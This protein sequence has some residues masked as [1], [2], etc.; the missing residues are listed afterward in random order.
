[1][2]GLQADSDTVLMNCYAP[3]LVNVNKGAWQWG[4]NL[5]GYDA[6]SSFGS[7]SYYAQSMFAGNL[8][9]VNLATDVIPQMLPLPPVETPHG[10]IGVGTTRSNAEFKDIKVISGDQTLNQPDLAKK[11]DDWTP[12]TG[13]WAVGDGVLSQANATARDARDIAGDIG[14]RDY[15]LSLKARSLGDGGFAVLFHVHDADNMISLNVGGGDKADL[16]RI[17]GRDRDA[18]GESVAFTADTGKWYDVRI[19]LAGTDIKC[20]LDDKLLVQATD[21][22]PAPATPVFAAASRANDSGEVILKVVNVGG[23]SQQIEINLT[24]VSQVAKEADVETLTGQPEDANTV[25][26]PQKVSPE[27]T[28][29]TNAGAKFVYEFPQYSVSV[30][31]LKAK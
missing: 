21:T 3:L 19:A 27:K 31:R 14:W 16:H 2:T 20:Y 1:M 10:Q 25:D 12:G 9:D 17:S 30:I 7:A 15:T 22:P 29:I 5:I 23:T 18:L 28:T 24:G 11:S 8:G 4:T 26:A 13:D 6:A